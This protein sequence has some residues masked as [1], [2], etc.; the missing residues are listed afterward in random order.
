MRAHGA[1]C[2]AVVLGWV[3]CL[4]SCRDDP[5]PGPSPPGVA[6]TSDAET[7]ATPMTTASAEAPAS[8]LSAGA[9]S[10][11]ADAGA[12]V[13]DAGTD[14]AGVPPARTDGCPD[15]MVRVAGEYCPAVAQNCLKHHAEYENDPKGKTVSERCLVYQEPTRCLSKQRTP[16]DFCMDRYEYPNQVGELPRL[17]TDWYQA[18]K[19]CEDLGKRLCTEAEYNFAC[20]GPEMLPYVYGYTRNP[21]ICNIDKPYE[22]P[23]QSRRMLHYDDCLKDFRCRAELERLDQRHR[24]GSTHTCASWAGVIDLNGNVNEWVELPGKEPPDRSGLKGGWW[25]P[26]RGRCRPTVGF[27]KESDYG[28][29][30]GFRCC[31]DA[32]P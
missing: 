22:Q 6:P 28:Y 20:E 32:A 15:G 23:D 10:A 4:A 18:K 21:D 29:E 12:G 30:V 16:M 3:S 2:T 17:L 19:R 24:I 26:V 9:G 1:M 31:K 7:S 14:D 27:H 11:E 25:G 8:A 5:D 13:A